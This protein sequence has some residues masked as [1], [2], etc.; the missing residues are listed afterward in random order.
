MDSMTWVMDS[1]FFCT[2]FTSPDSSPYGMSSFEVLV[3]LSIYDV[4]NRMTYINLFNIKGRGKREWWK[5]MKGGGNNG[6]GR[7]GWGV[8]EGEGVVE[9]KGGGRGSSSGLNVTQVHSCSWVVVFICRQL[10]LSVGSCSCG[11]SPSLSL[12]V[13]ICFMGGQ[14]LCSWVFIFV[15]GW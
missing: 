15:H 6:G 9:S 8:M 4:L 11:Q 10:P 2:F 12:F 13:G 7:E 5:V 1:I 3:K 14:G